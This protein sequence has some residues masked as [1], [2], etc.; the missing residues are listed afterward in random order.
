LQSQRTK[1]VNDVEFADPGD[2]W[3]HSYDDFDRLTSADNTLDRNLH[4]RSRPAIC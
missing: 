1:I 2:S 3:I 4:L